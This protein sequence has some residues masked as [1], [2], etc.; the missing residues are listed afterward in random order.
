MIINKIVICNNNG[1]INLHSIVNGEV[2]DD[3]IGHS[4]DVTNL[5]LDYT[6]QLVVSTGWDSRIL[7]QRESE[8]D[9]LLRMQDKAH[10]K[11]EISLLDVSPSLIA[12][13]SGSIWLLWSYFTL[14][15]IGICWNSPYDFVGISFIPD[16][17]VLATTDNEPW[18]ILWSC[19]GKGNISSQDKNTGVSSSLNYE[20]DRLIK[21]ELDSNF[22]LMLFQ[23]K[24]D[25]EELI[26][27]EY[28]EANEEILKYISRYKPHE[29]FQENRTKDKKNSKT[30][31][32]SILS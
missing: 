24:V 16:Y 5:Y 29:V 25:V 31:V 20:M 6:N 12:T 7:I 10:I 32:I 19:K 17:P 26:E 1:E 27:T 28:D 2:I 30:I 3:L 4:S 8:N 13:C 21:I 18:I 22:S 11:N 14:K 15:F 23:I 9:S